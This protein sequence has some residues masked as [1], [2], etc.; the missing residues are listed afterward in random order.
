MA[1]SSKSIGNLSIKI[2]AEAQQANQALE[3]LIRNVTNLGNALNGVDTKTFAK[4]RCFTTQIKR[5]KRHLYM[6]QIQMERLRQL[7]LMVYRPK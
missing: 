6:P 7:L 4:K 1:N 5:V 3:T 2:T